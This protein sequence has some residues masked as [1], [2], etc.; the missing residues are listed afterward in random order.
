MIP[1]VLQVGVFKFYSR[2]I[3]ARPLHGAG[4][5]ALR[6]AVIAPMLEPS[7]QRSRKLGPKLNRRRALEFLADCRADAGYNDHARHVTKAARSY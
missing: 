5:T 6:P 7:H 3:P 2:L 4:H 1:M